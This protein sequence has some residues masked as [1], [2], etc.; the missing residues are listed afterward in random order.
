MLPTVVEKYISDHF[1]RVMDMHV[2]YCSGPHR[3]M[4]VLG[5]KDLFVA[6]TDEDAP[7]AN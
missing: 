3:N 4:L 7:C 2:G 6:A 5:V 1:G